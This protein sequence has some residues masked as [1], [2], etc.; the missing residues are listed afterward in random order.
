MVAIL[1]DITKF[2]C[3]GPVNKFD[4]TAQNETNL[5]HCFLQL[6]K[7]DD[8][9]KMVYEVIRPTGSQRLI[10]YGL[11]KIHKQDVP[12]CPILLIIIS[13]QHVLAKFLATLLQPIRTLLN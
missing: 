10:M 6:I 8:L 2:E 5:Q 13:A 1:S 4:N 7:S 3:L 11:P 9:L 12:C